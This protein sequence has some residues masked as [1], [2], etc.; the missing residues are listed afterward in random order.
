M[1]RCVTIVTLLILL[2]TAGAR[3][4]VYQSGDLAGHIDSIIAS[5]PVT[6]DGGD[7]LQPN[8]ASRT[9]W[10]EIVDH[11]LAGE[12][13][14]A[15][16]DALTRSYQ[17]VLFTDTGSVDQAV[18]VVLERTPESTSRYWGTFV[19]NPEPHRS[20]LV[21]QSPHPRYDTNTGYQGIRIYQHAGAKAFFVS[22]THR[23]NG[24][25]LSPC[26][27]TTTACDE[28]AQ[29]YRYSDMAHVVDSAFQVTTQAL[30]DNDTLLLV[31]QPHGFAQETGDPDLIM[32]NG[33]RTQPSGTDWVVAIRDAIL[34]IDTSLTAKV[35]HVNLTWTRLLATENTQ[36]RLINGSSDPCG[37]A[38]TSATGGFVHVEQA[39]I[40][41][42][43]TAENWMK[44]ATAIADAVP[45]DD[46]AV[47]V[48]TEILG[49]V[50]R[51]IGNDANPFF[52]R[53][54][55]NFELGQPGPVEME[56]F[57][58]AGRRVGRLA[59]GSY[60]AGVH[61]LEWNARQLPAGTYFLRL[62]QGAGLAIRRCV[63]LH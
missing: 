24:L 26:D 21:I 58:L 39:R 38:A 29:S 7:Y 53:T 61:S 33:T 6:V 47:S 46:S 40:G 50:V 35:A 4:Q 31:V 15:H 18:H 59:S 11:I 10:R 13:A 63:L 45:E 2:S 8:L 3:A 28:T 5:M 30:L 14:D 56:V 49:P 34:A 9:L 25:T 22:G 1:K 32:S 41:L 37:T 42:R 62:R 36:G 12:Y 16:V 20:H 19:F 23:C 51:I 60:S 55:I 27:G 17:V 44:L 43:D 57:D 54:R 48:D 52:G